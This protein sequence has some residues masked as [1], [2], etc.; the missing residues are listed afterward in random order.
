[1]A[2]GLVALL[3]DVAGIAKIAA[4]SLDDVTAAA[5]K[6]GSKAVGVVVD[7]TAVTPGYA[8]GFTPDREL[9][10][11]VKIAI[12]SLRNKFFF[13]LPGALLLSAFAPWAITPILMTGGAYLAFEATEKIIEALAHHDTADEPQE[14]AL[15]AKELENQ[16]VSGAIRTDLILSGEIVAISLADVASQPLAIQ[17]AALA[18]VGLG[19]TIGVYGV[20]GL[21]VKMDDIGLHLAG[22]KARA[23]QAFGRFLVKAMPKTMEAL[24]VIG[25]AAMLWVGGGIIVHGLEHFHLTPIPRWVEALSHAAGAAPGVGPLAGWLAMAAGS[26]VVGAAVGALIV[27]VLHLI[28]RRKPH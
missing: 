24:T 3:D 16:K 21:I 2:S 6:A 12:G 17:A 27:G 14:L 11:V 25:T 7:D 10:I 9:P 18:L 19:I 23:S 28:P 22:R 4:A 20:V 5:G 13:L 8:M 15:S 26:A 1:M